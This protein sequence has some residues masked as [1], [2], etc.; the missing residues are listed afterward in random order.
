MDGNM[1]AGMAGM[2]DGAD[3]PGGFCIEIC[4]SAEGKITVESGPLD[5]DESGEEG[6]PV[7]SIDAALA[8]AKDLY[9]QGGGTGDEAFNEGYGKP[10]PSPMLVRTREG[11]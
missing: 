11:E 4:V 5:A 6:I 8:K 1:M 9:A 10:A 2:D 7:E 3:T